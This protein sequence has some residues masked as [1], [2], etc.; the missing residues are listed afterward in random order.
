VEGQD[1]RDAQDLREVA[2]MMSTRGWAVCLV[3]LNA[4]RENIIRVVAGGETKGPK[5][6]WE[7][8]QGMLAGFQRAVDIF[9]RLQEK[10]QDLE[11]LA[12]QDQE[13]KID[14]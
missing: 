5:H 10:Y 13:G 9:D 12:R 7:Y 1:I 3:S 8:Y 2:R 6:G 11:A 4:D 14:E